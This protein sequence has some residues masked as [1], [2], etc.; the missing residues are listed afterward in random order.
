[1]ALHV[2]PLTHDHVSAAANLMARRYRRLRGTIP[3]LPARYGDEAVLT[4]MLETMVGCAAGVA[5]MEGERLAG[6][7]AGVAIPEFKGRRAVLSPEWANAAI[8]AGDGGGS[9]AIYER[10]YTAVADAWAAAGCSCHLIGQ[11]PDDAGALD[12]W[13]HQGFGLLCIDAVRDLRPP[14]ASP[15]EV[16]VRA[17]GPAD[18]PALAALARGLADHLRAAPVFLDGCPDDESAWAPQLVDAE[19]VLYVAIASGVPVAYMRI[20]PANDDACGIIVDEGTASITGAF[21]IPDVRRRGVATALLRACLAW[22]AERG[23]VRCAV[24]WESANIEGNRFWRQHFS[25][26]CYSLMR[27]VDEAAIAAG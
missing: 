27:C 2:V 26:V 5:A 24:D 3:Q 16:E 1:M 15:A 20:G 10:M 7:I 12:G 22:A 18:A 13:F 21:A 11:F 8:P 19:R 23:Y 25:P 4:P 6:F 14:D 9:R 17:A